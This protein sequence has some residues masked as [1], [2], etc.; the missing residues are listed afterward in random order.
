M[1]SIRSPRCAA[2]I[3]AAVAIG[4]TSLVM[5]SQNAQ[6]ARAAQAA[7]VPSPPKAFEEL[8]VPADNPLTPEK[9]ALGR[10]LFFDK[11]L[12]GDGSRS[13]YS[14]HVCEKGLTDG[15]PVAIG[16]YEKKLPRSSP[17]LWNIGYHTEFYWDGRSASLEKQ[18]VAAWSGANMGAKPEEIVKQLNAMPGYREQ[19]Q[20]VFG[21]DATPDA[22]GKALAAYERTIFCGDT[23]WDKY[24]QGE[25]QA[26]SPAAERGW[27]VWREKAG[28]GSCHAGILFT[29]LQYHNT[30]VGLDKPEPDAGRGKVTSQ[31]AHHGA[32]KTPTLR[33]ISKSAPYFHDGS[34]ATLEEAVDFM[35][36]GG[37]A[38][39]NLDKNMTKVT[40]TAA[41]RSDLI[42]LLKS[43][44]CGCTLKEP[45][46]PR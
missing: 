24:N 5:L 23:A 9:V 22:V 37:R 15:L 31:P 32:F 44:D 41:E 6:Q 39:P 42:A 14:C 17:S 8:V 34:V 33:D 10:Q 25:K 18:A 36:G 19:F 40:L 28:C 43:L 35:L 30:G 20:K 29:D 27:N 3:I 11:R 38:N 13:C 16:A 46:L 7:A 26:L 4:A 45:T 1:R 12:S 21:A 2:M